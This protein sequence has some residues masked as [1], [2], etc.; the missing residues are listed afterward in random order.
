MNFSVFLPYLV[1]M[2]GVTYLVRMLPLVLTRKKFDNRFVKSFLYYVPYTVLGTMTFPAILSSTSSVISA[3]VGFLTALLFA[4]KEK[5]L[6]IV[7][8]AAGVSALVTEVLLRV[9]F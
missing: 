7:A 5:S 4:V 9:S 1:V 8:I 6:L 2:A 3:G